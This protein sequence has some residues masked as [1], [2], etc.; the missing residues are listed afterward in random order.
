MKIPDQLIAPMLRLTRANSSFLTTQGAR[1]AVRKQSLRPASYNPPARVRSDLNITVTREG[2]VPTYTIAPTLNPPAVRLI[3]THGGGWVHEI[4]RF[5]WSLLFQLAAEAHA[6][7][8]VPIWT[9]LPFGDAR[10]ANEVVLRLHDQLK[11]SRE[12]VVVAGDSAGGQIALSAAL[13]LRDR[14]LANVRTVLISPALDLSM[15]NA[16][17]ALVLPQD[18]WLGIDGI[19]YLGERWRGE[20]PL[21]DPLV[22][23]LRGDFHG[24]GSM[25]VFSGTHDVLNPDANLLVDKVRA[26][27]A[28]VTFVERDGAVHVFPLLPT[29]MG[30]ASRAVVV[31]FLS[32]GSRSDRLDIGEQ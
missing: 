20:L 24:L 13:A 16:R 10:Q 21:A 26:T 29:P 5:H 3:Y 23:P 8:T 9:K 25:L 4:S 15:S 22:S 32:P 1:D 27:G 18:P 17:S 2:G 6:A 19:R 12:E 28:E 11:E 14:G 30:A 31:G 7:I